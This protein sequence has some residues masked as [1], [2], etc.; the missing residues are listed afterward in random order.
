MWCIYTAYTFN[1]QRESTWKQKFQRKALNSR[2]QKKN[3]LK[4][5][6]AKNGHCKGLNGTGTG[7]DE[8][9]MKKFLYALYK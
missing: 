6:Q 3:L 9:D 1:I 7:M 5:V 2:L 4:E 8:G